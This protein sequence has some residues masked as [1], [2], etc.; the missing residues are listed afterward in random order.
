MYIILV[1]MCKLC[2]G[3]CCR[4]ACITRNFFKT[5]NPQLINESGFNSRAA[6]NGVRTVLAYNVHIP[7]YEHPSKPF[8]N[9]LQN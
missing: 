1:S 9:K 4:A 6:Y 8:F 5:Q 2:C 3:L 7:D